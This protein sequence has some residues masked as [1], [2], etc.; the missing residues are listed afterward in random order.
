[1]LKLCQRNVDC[2][3]KDMEG[4]EDITVR[5]LD[6]QHPFSEPCERIHACIAARHS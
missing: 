6:W 2:S 4:C 5:E 1:M 3:I